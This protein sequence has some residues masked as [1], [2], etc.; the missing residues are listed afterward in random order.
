L[1]LNFVEMLDSIKDELSK[2]N[3]ELGY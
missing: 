1:E 3:V 2:L